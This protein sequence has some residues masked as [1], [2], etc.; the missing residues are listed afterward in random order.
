MLEVL[1]LRRYLLTG[2]DILNEVVG[3]R[4]IQLA[5]NASDAKLF[6]LGEV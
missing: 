4:W 5:S 6:M 3:V 1:T 2:F